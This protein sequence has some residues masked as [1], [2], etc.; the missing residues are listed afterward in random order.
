MNMPSAQPSMRYSGQCARRVRTADMSA[1][2]LEAGIQRHPAVD[3]E[4]D[5]VHVI[6]VIG[7]K[8]D[9][10]PTD[11]VGL[12]DA[13]VWDQLEQLCVRFRRAPCFHVDR[14]AYRAGA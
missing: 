11:L 12:A 2:R 10:C 6:R 8:P 9:R 7:C 3:E 13:L 4:A 1:S 5:A 14:R